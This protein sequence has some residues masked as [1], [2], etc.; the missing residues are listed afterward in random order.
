MLQPLLLINNKIKHTCSQQDINNSH[1]FRTKSLLKDIPPTP[2]PHQKKRRICYLKK[3][4][5]T[6][7]EPSTDLF[8]YSCKPDQKLYKAFFFHS[9]W[10]PDQRLNKPFSSL[11][12]LRPPLILTTTSVRLNLHFSSTPLYLYSDSDS[13]PPAHSANTDRYT[14]RTHWQTYS[15]NPGKHTWTQT[16]NGNTWHTHEHG[17]TMW[18]LTHS[19]TQAHKGNTDTLVDTG[20]QREHWHTHEH[21]HT[22][23]T[24]T[25]SWAQA[26]KGNT[27]TL[28]DTGTQ[29]EHW[30]ATV[31]LT[32]A[33]IQAHNRNTDT[34]MN[35]GTQWEHWHIHEPRHTMGTLTCSL[36]IDTQWEHWQTREHKHSTGTLTHT[37]P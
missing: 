10:K 15:G 23:G 11:E 34:L 24:L 28:M 27:D 3:K 7:S 2:P 4:I 16:L 25:H 13:K 22:K 20:T 32:H 5:S 35:T 1:N 36:V 14:L 30:H 31:T 8:H 29:R 18:T 6:N 33:W 17:H 19:W 37:W 26:H 9:D 12:M 21:R